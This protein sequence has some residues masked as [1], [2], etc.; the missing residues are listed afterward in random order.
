MVRT[1]NVSPGLQEVQIKG[2]GT[3][4]PLREIQLIPQVSGKVVFMSDSLVN[5]GQFRKGDTL[6]RIDPV[7]YRLAVTLAQAQV[8]DSESKLKLALFSSTGCLVAT[9]M[10]RWPSNVAGGMAGAPHVLNPLASLRPLRLVWQTPMQ[11][12]DA[13]AAVLLARA[14]SW[15]SL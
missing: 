6:L 12:G 4:Q 14:C 1:I 13:V 7:D 3:V 10:R 9:R 15:P 11:D 5:G 8:K 2:E